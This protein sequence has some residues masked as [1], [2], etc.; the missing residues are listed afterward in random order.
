MMG[1]LLCGAL[2]LAL[3]LLALGFLALC[4]KYRRR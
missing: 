4:R 2:F 3:A 1:D